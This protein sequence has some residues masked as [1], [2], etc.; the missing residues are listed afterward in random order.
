M[1]PSHCTMSGT[2][3]YWYVLIPGDV[4][5]YHLSARVLYYLFLL[6]LSLTNFSI[7][8]WFVPVAVISVVF[9]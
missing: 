4:T 3:Y 2:R 8:K 6:K 1:C 9:K 5:P 7:R